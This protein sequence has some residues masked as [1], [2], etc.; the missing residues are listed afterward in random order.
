MAAYRKHK[1]GEF[2]ETPQNPHSISQRLETK[3]VARYGLEYVPIM[4][5]HKPNPANARR[6]K[7]WVALKITAK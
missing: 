2:L 3:N 1:Y 4:Q 7:N 6:M 5:I